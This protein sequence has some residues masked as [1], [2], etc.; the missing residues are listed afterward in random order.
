MGSILNEQFSLVIPTF[1]WLHI[2]VQVVPSYYW[3]LQATILSNK[4]HGLKVTDSMLDLS[5]I[6]TCET[7][8][9]M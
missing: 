5:N 8:M 6:F 4:T 9:R 2:R 3:Y 1:K 7:T